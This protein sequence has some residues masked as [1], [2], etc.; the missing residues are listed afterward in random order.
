M[1]SWLLVVVSG[2]TS[3]HGRKYHIKP[4]SPSESR[5]NWELC[6]VRL[7][8]VN[9]HLRLYLYI[10]FCSELLL[11]ALYMLN[12]DFQNIDLFLG[13]DIYIHAKKNTIQNS[14]FLQSNECKCWFTQ[15]RRLYAFRAHKGIC[16]QYW[17]YS[18]AVRKKKFDVISIWVIQRALAQP[19]DF[20][21]PFCDE[22]ELAIIQKK[23]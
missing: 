18:T 7:P 17:M 6:D 22:T 21:F 14:K 16:D 5:F 13:P 3:L 2:I 12:L 8:W 20:C 9:Q 19:G 23:I 4:C 15:G 10:I 11:W 1:L